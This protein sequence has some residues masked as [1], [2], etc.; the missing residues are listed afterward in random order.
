MMQNDNTTTA[1][2]KYIDSKAVVIATAAAVA[3]N[4]A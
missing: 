1:T 4:N 2:K 3:V